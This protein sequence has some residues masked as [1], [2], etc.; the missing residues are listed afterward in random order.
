MPTLP[1]IE[2]PLIGNSLAV[3][4]FAL[5]HILLAGLGVGFMM[6]APLAESLGETRPWLLEAARSMTR[7]T[8]VTYTA[9]MVLAVVMVDLFIGLFPLTNQHLFNRF[10]YPIFVAM[11]AFL[12]QLF[13]LYPYYHYW[14]ALR[15]RSPGVHRALG[16][17]AAAL[18][19]IWVA[20][21]DGIGSYMLTPAESD[22]AWSRLSNPTWVP[23][24][25]HRFFGNLVMAGYVMAGYAAWRLVVARREDADYYVRLLKIG[26]LIGFIMLMIQPLSGLLYAQAISSSTPDA[27]RQ[28]TQ[29]PYQP[30]VYA[31]FVLIGSLFLG[32]HL[33]LQNAPSR[34]KA[35]RWIVMAAGLLALAMVLSVGH[36]DLRRVWTFALVILSAVALYRA[37]GLF[38]EVAPAQQY[39]RP[40]IRYL[41]TALA[42]IAALTYLTMGTIRETARRPDTVRT[43]IS[44]HD[45]ARQP[46]LDRPG[47]AEGQAKGKAESKFPD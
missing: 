42:I 16:F 6:L 15:A 19:F 45:E 20:V 32:S 25:V 38:T 30:W 14:D 31:Q 18:M 12:L 36:P 46:A 3:G 9:S 11:I 10:R 41:S 39:Q 35:A 21:L 7:F 37:R 40:F 33:W 5:L 24:V 26:L 1:A 44:L 23:L 29:G 28:L 4:L 8:V 47:K 34:G 17:L 2:F 22:G 13:A 43:I 27:Y